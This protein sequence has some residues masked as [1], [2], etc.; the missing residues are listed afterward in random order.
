MIK[1]WLTFW[2]FAC[3]GICNAQNPNWSVNENEYQYSMTITA[4]LNINGTTLSNPNDKVAAFINNEVRGVANVVYNANGDKY[5]AYL[6]VFS[7]NNN[8]TISF[9]IYDST[10]DEVIDIDTTINF[11]IDGN[12]G[13]TFQSLSLANPPLSDEARLTS[14]SFDGITANSIEILENSVN[15]ELPLNTDVNNLVANFT[16]SNNATVFVDKVEQI[17]GVTSKSYTSP[18]TFLVLSEDESVAKEYEIKVSVAT[19]IYDIDITLYT[20]KTGIINNNVIPVNVQTSSELTSLKREDFVSNHAIAQT[21]TKINENNY[22]VIFLVFSQTDF[23]IEIPFNQVQNSEGKRNNRSNKLSFSFDNIKPYIQLIRRKTPTTEVT[24]A[25]SVS[26][27]ITFSEAVI[28]VSPDDFETITNAN[29][30]IT[31]E[32][33]KTY[34]VTI[35]NIENYNGSVSVSLKPTNDIVDF[36]GNELRTSTLKNY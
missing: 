6:T 22:S 32:N 31:Q 7:N 1:T 8:E 27:T 5:V 2:L 10:A 13:S 26:F 23:S 33:S 18:I 24:N 28:N 20:P 11:Q 4:F 21:I 12:I 29:L 9:K 19:T 25:N 36:A 17:S 35:S 3:I 16:T 14:F 34:T 15:I 30:I